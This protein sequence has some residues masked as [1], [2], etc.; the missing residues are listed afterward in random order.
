MAAI[1]PLIF[2]NVTGFQGQYGIVVRSTAS[3]MI[4]PG[5]QSSQHLLTLWPYAGNKLSGLS[6][7]LHEMWII[8]SPPQ[9][10][11]EDVN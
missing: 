2:P 8:M 10:C 7:L 6:F 5:F 11:S 9:N 3:E 4:L 1:M